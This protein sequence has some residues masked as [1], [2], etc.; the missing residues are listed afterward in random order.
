[1]NED[2]ENQ[3]TF[4]EFDELMFMIRKRYTKGTKIFYKIKTKIFLNKYVIHLFQ[5]SNDLIRYNNKETLENTVV[6]DDKKKIKI[7]L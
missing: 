2:A 4:K 3:D 7:I 5:M 1:M 6:H